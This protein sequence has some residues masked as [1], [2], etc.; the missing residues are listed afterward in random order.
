MIQSFINFIDRNDLDRKEDEI[1]I[2]FINFN[3]EC[4][5]INISISHGVK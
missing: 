2:L 1:K 5:S 3:K 4:I